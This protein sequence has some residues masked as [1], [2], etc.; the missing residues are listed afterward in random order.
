MVV[1]KLDRLARNLSLLLEIEKTLKEHGITLIS[2]K[3]SVDTST[4]TVRWPFLFLEWS[5]NGTGQISSSAHA[6]ED[7]KDTRKGAGAAANRL[8]GIL[9]IKRLVN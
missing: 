7:C 9:T 3:E 8:M 2:M 1:F 6:M 5:A 4:P